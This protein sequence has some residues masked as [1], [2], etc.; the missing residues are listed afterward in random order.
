MTMKRAKIAISLGVAIAA[1]SGMARA[2]E[3]RTIGEKIDDDIVSIET[4]GGRTVVKTAK[5]KSIALSEVKH[6][7]FEEGAARFESDQNVVLVNKDELHGQVSAWIPKGDSFSLKTASLGNVTV[8]IDSVAA[9]FFG[10]RALEQHHRQKN[11]AWLEDPKFDGR[12]ANDSVFIH[13]GGKATG[14]V[15]SIANTGIE[16]DAQGIGKQTFAIKDVDA[17]VTGNVG[18]GPPP[19]PAKGTLVRVRCVDGS[20]ISGVVVKLTNGTLELDHILDKIQIPTKE[21]LELFV[22]NGAFVYVSDL[23]PTKVDQHFMPAFGYDPEIWGWKKDK[24]CVDG[25]PLR[26]GGRSYDKGLGVHS[27]CALTY[28]INGAFKEFRAT[29]GL[30]D[31]IKYHGLPNQGEVTF[32]VLVGDEKSGMKVAKELLLKDRDGKVTEGIL[33]KRGDAPYE[34]TVNVEGVE[35]IALIAD[36]GRSLHILGRA[37]WADAHFVKR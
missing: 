8:K 37:D 7:R 21:I 10:G 26:L 25:D 34:L 1:L 16:L 30:D 36:Y 9:I 22:L 23:T 20:S 13:A 19:A 31:V 35:Q 4:Q 17:L 18:G 33:M 15:N 28:A 24:A 2:A 6:I 11:L 5:G 3:I 12:P 27:Y 14:T 32:K 29:I